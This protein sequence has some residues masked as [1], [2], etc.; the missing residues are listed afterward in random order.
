[1]SIPPP[2]TPPSGLTSA[3]AASRLAADGPNAVADVAQHPI[4]RALGKLWAPIP[5][6][7]EAAILL[8]LALGEYIEASAVTLLLVANAAL[9]FF[10]ESRAQATL[11]ALK[12]RLAMTAAVRR[13]GSWQTI[14]AAGLVRGDLVKLSLGAVVPA[15]LRLTGGGVLIDQSMLTGESI[16]VEAASGF[17]AFAGGL[18]RRGEA[19]GTVMAT[20]ERTKFARS[21]D[22]IRSAHIE[23]TEQKAIFRVVRNLALFNGGATLVLIAVALHLGMSAT[24]MAPLVLVALLATIP[25]A[26]PSMFTLAAT[27]GARE[28]ARHGV[29][30]TRLSALDEAAGVDVLCAD[31]TGTLTRNELA[32]TDCQAFPGF[33]PG[34]VMAMAALASS[35]GGA[36]P[37][38]AAIRLATTQADLA[39]WHLVSFTPFDPGE[40]MSEA[41]ATNAA[42]TTLRIVKGAL[43]AVAARAATPPGA[44][45][46]VAALQ[47]KGY[48]VLVVACGPAN[49]LAIAGMIALSDP[50][51]ADSKA[52][53]AALRALGVRTLMVTGDAAVT[54]RVVADQVGITG[55]ICDLAPLP[56]NLDAA[57]FDV[58]AGVLPAEKFAL[59]QSLQAGGHVVAMCGDGANDAP[60]LRQ[61]QMGIA[62]STATD[63]AKAAAGMVLTEP[64]LEGIL[65]AVREGRRTF[66]RIL[67]YTLRS[68]THKV[69]QVLLLLAGLMLTGGAVL[70]PLLMV[71][72]MVAGDFSALSS[73]TD[74]VTP[75]PRPNT[76][77]IGNLTIVGIVLGICDLAYCITWLAIGSHLLL[78]DAETMRT[79]TVVTKVTSGQAVFYVSRERRRLWASR[80]GPWLMVMSSLDVALFATLATQGILM[81]PLPF[82]VV[83]AV[84]GAAVLLALCLDTLKL[85][86]FRRFPIT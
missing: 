18:I 29:L 54:A 16:P 3:E 40:K 64:G 67:T 15:D 43:A 27:V 68:I 8:Q 66:Q 77:R 26:L 32:V 35:D 75:S 82:A 23:S 37:L 58:F 79:L 17:D 39:G 65:V 70:T 53:I 57:R 55:P 36:D 84:I 83:A 46:A 47:A 71:L 85:L 56:P 6:L 78:L 12:S 11:D 69:G 10:Q 45:A 24:T 33:T 51:R 19:I 30:P 59:V 42:G 86:M 22:L 60:A 4:Q 34:Q 14:P 61:A 1:M 44:A 62:V 2:D 81:S 31:K 5:W 13:D 38:D 52:L 80:P 7:L 73:S 76:W 20:G 63:V 50:P 74:N 48:R 49:A 28:I 41:M 9:S 25:V 72:M 21:A